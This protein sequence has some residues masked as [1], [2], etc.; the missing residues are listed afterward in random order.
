MVKNMVEFIVDKKLWWK[1]LRSTYGVRNYG[2]KTS[3][4]NN[5]QETMVKV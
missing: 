2:E 4:E 1:E 5:E 3:E